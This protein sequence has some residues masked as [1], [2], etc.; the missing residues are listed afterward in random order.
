MAA[1]CAYSVLSPHEGLTANLTASCAPPWLALVVKSRHEKSV[2]TILDSKGYRTAL[3]LVRCIHKRRSGSDW[4]S[5]KPLIAGY[6]FAAHD[7][8]NP[9]R[10]VTTPGVVQIVSFGSAPGAISD[11]EIAALE[12]IAASGLPVAGC[13]Y[14]RVGEAV[15]LIDGPLKGMQ[16]LV[17]RQAKTTRLVVGVELL[18]RSVAVEIDGAWAV[19]IR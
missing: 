11:E 14:T 18:Q 10:M 19:P 6:V 8:N 15:E 5:Q 16:G 7:W 1:A 2:K 3:P 17:L 9:Y 13:G 4:D 12:R